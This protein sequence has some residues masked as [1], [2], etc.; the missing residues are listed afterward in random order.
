[1][2]SPT[3]IPDTTPATVHGSAVAVKGRGL[4]FV[5]PSGSGKSSLALQIIALG[6]GTLISDDLVSLMYDTAGPVLRH[7]EGAAE[8]GK[9][10]ARGVGLLQVS[11]TTS[12]PLCLIVDMATAENARLPAPVVHKIDGLS[13]P[14]LKKVETPAFPA[15]LLTYVAQDLCKD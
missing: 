2:A 7:P 13:V 6:G 11:M 9:I 1:M 8:V 15:L 14:L 10:E 5:G 12:A 4:L 3:V